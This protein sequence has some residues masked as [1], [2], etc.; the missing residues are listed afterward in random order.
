MASQLPHD[1]LIITI[2]QNPQSAE[3]AHNIHKHAGVENRINI[4]IGSTE[5]VIPQ[6]SKQYHIDSFDLI[7]ID[8]SG[9]AYLRDF[10]LLEQYGLIKSGT[11]IVADNVITPGAPDYLNYIQN[12]PNYKTKTYE[13]TIEYREDVRDGVEITI[14]K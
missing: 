3:I 7:F 1:T 5:K 11:M 2:E 6:L 8:H 4:L 14:R 13:S 12:N 10:M 9:H